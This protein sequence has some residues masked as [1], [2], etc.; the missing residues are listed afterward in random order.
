MDIRQFFTKK[1]GITTFDEQEGV[2]ERLGTLEL[3]LGDDEL[4]RLIDERIAKA[5]PDKTAMDKINENNEAFYLGQQVDFSKLHSHQS[6]VVDNR[7]YLGID[8]L[9]PILATKKR[10]PVVMPAQNTDESRELAQLGQSYL[11]WKWDEQN[12]QTKLADIVRFL[13][14]H[15]FAVLKYRFVAGSYNDFEVEVKRPE[16]IIIDNKIKPTFIG[17]YLK[18]SADEIIKKFAIKEDGKVDEVKKKK[19]LTVLA[20]DEKQLGTEVTYLEFWTPDL[21][22]WKLKGV[23]LDKAKN[24]NW[25]WDTKGKQFNHLLEPEMPFVLLSWQ[26]FLKGIYSSTTSLEQAMP[27]QRNIN[28]RK[29]QISDNA[30]QA[31]GTFIFNEKY[32][33]RKEASKF[34]G[35]PNQHIM[36]NGDGSVNDAVGRVLPKDLGQQVYLD[37]QDDKSEVDNILGVHATTR[38]ERGPQKTLGEARL[39]K[40]SDYGRLD[41]ISQYIDQKCKELYNAFI[42]MSLVY[43][44]EM[45]TLKILG[46]ENSQD[47]IEFSRDN[48]EDGIELIVRSEPLMSQAEEMNKYMLLFQA[49]LVDPLTMYERL[50][51]PNPKELTRRKLLLDFD[52]KAYLAEFAMDENSPGME[53]DPLVVAKEDIKKLEAK[54]RVEPFVNVTQDHIKEHAKYMKSGKFKVLKKDVQ[55]N[56]IE[57]VRGEIE[58]LKGQVKQVKGE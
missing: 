27:I 43:Y 42:Q 9:V 30:D 40:E 20:L 24:P 49:N 17:E 48:I 26:T 3:G 52:P 37:L 10:E 1:Q 47:Y 18:E 5:T 45:K 23:I 14:I 58:I 25:L 53:N 51:L 15:R 46:P 32:I 39:L 19:I 50:N 33:S 16:S 35:A 28:K 8:T 44:D 6:R 57:H 55:Q 11:S 34:K 29:R 36:Y 56:M 38:G 12:M 7:I 4:V 21:V 2:G 13:N 22:V 54:E 41:L 31:S